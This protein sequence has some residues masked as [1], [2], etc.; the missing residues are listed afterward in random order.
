MFCHHRFVV[1]PASGLGV[2]SPFRRIRALVN[3]FTGPVIFVKLSRAFVPHLP[4]L[5]HGSVLFRELQ[6]FSCEI[7]PSWLGRPQSAAVLARH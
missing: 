1:A 7:F 4:L 3:S 6:Y 5:L 2:T